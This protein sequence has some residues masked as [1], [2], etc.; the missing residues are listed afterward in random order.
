MCAALGSET[1]ASRFPTGRSS[2]QNCSRS[3][4]CRRRP[5]P[6]RSPASARCCAASRP[7][8]TGRQASAC[9]DSDATEAV[10]VMRGVEDQQRPKRHDARRIYPLMA[11][12][13]VLLDVLEIDGVLDP[14]NLE[15][16][17][18]IAGQ[19]RVFGDPPTVAFE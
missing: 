8:P 13:I 16:V 1:A 15:K 12:I 5:R 17:A 19:V 18:K 10:P 4:A 11:V 2:L 9:R 3:I 6:R 7:R 14:G